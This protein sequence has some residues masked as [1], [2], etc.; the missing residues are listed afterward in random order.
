MK[1]TTKTGVVVEINTR[2][3]YGETW[4]YIGY[5]SAKKAIGGFYDLFRE[6]DASVLYFPDRASYLAAWIERAGEQ[7]GPEMVEAQSNAQAI[8]NPGGFYEVS[9][10]DE[11]HLVPVLAKLDDLDELRLR[12]QYSGTGD[13]N[14]HILTA[15]DVLTD[16]R[17]GNDDEFRMAAYA[18]DIIAQA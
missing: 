9:A 5:E 16:S 11:N 1:T 12:A 3:S 13:D 17:L 2:H 6:K 7:E 8:D 4:T 14:I 10:W 15:D 18:A